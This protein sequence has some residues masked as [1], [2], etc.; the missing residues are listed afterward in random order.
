VA[1]APRKRKEESMSLYLLDMRGRDGKPDEVRYHD[2]PLRVGEAVDL[3]G[4]LWTVAKAEDTA[5]RLL[6][7]SGASITARYVCQR[8]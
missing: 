1:T 3:N 7:P 4:K 6:D 8:Q 5:G 2:R